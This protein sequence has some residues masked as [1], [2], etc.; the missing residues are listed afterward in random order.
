VRYSKLVTA[1]TA[2]LEV[3]QVPQVTAETVELVEQEVQL[4][5]EDMVVTEPWVEMV[6]KS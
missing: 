5:Q 6:V 1:V 4:E 3:L 2:E